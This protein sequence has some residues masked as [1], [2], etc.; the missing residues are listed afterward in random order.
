MQLRFCSCALGRF[1]SIS[2]IYIPAFA[3]EESYHS[4]Q[5]CDLI[6][7]ISSPPRR[8]GDVTCPHVHRRTYNRG[9]LREVAKAGRPAGLRPAPLASFACDSLCFRDTPW[10]G[11]V[12]NYGST[13][14]GASDRSSD[15]SGSWQDHREVFRAVLGSFVSATQ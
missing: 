5:L 9:F 4:Q 7:L 14:V 11:S 6:Y 10:A 1:G 12:Y 8:T 2:R 3:P 13:I 15:T